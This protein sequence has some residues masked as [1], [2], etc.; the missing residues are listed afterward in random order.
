MEIRPFRGWRHEVGPDG[1]VSAYIAPPYDI[2][3]EADKQELLAG[4]EKNIVAV[5]LP[6]C[7]PKEVGPEEAYQAAAETLSRWKSSG[8]LRQDDRPAVYIYEQSYNW[9][10][11]S[12]TR[13]ALICGVRASELGRD[14]IPHEQ[15]FAGPKADRLKLTEQTQM[16]LSPIFGFYEDPTGAIDELL[17]PAASSKPALHGKL[18]NV[19]QRLW[20]VTDEETISEIAFL[21]RDVPAFIADGHHRYT[22]AMNYRDS[23]RADGLIDDDHEA[24]FV[25]FA[26]V[27]GGDPG[28]LVLPTHRIVHGLREG[29]ALPQ[30]IRKAP[31]F[32]WRRVSVDDVDLSD[33]DRFLGRY[34]EGAMAFL[35]AEP[36]EIWIAKLTDPDAMQAAAPDKCDAWCRLDVA[37]LHKLIIDQALMPWRTDNLFIEYT[38][39]GKAVL[40]ACRS[41]RAQLGVCLQ[42]TPLQA[43]Q[44]I[45][46]AGQSMPHKSTYFYPKLATGMVLKPLQ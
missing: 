42:G 4:S 5:D 44:D 25:M 9:A 15:T 19:E 1:D 27:S 46:L 34:G 24:N 45:A 31:Q 35:G 11:R 13:R 8:T 33:A 43:V 36:A 10:G 12:Y 40:A 7:P 38:P 28:L 30:L 26:L 3:T 18:R 37:I 21:L 29:F 32:D 20:V 22:T 14:V 16:Q 17:G 2:L 23:L 39:D 41:G 6:H